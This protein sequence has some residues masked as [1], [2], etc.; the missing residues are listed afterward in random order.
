MILFHK[1]HSQISCIDCIAN[2]HLITKYLYLT[3]YSE[4]VLPPLLEQPSGLD[5]RFYRLQNRLLSDI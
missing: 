4:G 3:V 5:V 2:I 1:P